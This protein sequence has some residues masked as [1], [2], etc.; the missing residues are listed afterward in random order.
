ML[1]SNLNI[2]WLKDNTLDCQG[3][4]KVEPHNLDCVGIP[5]VEPL[6]ID[7]GYTSRYKK[8][9]INMRILYY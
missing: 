4:P 6:N 7:F 2:I 5:I 9:I 8:Y 1:L 3:I